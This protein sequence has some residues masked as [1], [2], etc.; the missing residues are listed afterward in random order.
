MVGSRILRAVP[1]EGGM[2]GRG[3][4]RLILTIL[5]LALLALPGAPL[6]H[7]AHAMPQPCAADTAHHGTDHAPADGHHL[8]ACCVLG[9]CA[10]TLS[11]LPLA[12]A[13]AIVPA[14]RVVA[15]DRADAREGIAP[16]PPLHPPRATA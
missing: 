4:G 1:M 11:P 15:T 5:A 3:L 9:G 2:L 16:G 12:P 6:R 10:A 14:P 13:P 7:A 8:P